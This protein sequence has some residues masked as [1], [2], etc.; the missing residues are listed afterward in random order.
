MQHLFPIT[1]TLLKFTLVYI[2]ISLFK[3]VYG[4]E[5]KHRLHILSSARRML[6]LAYPNANRGVPAKHWSSEGRKLGEQPPALLSKDK[7]R[8]LPSWSCWTTRTCCLKASSPLS[9]PPLAAKQDASSGLSV[10][11]SH[12]GWKDIGKLKPS[13]AELKTQSGQRIFPYSIMMDII[14]LS[15]WNEQ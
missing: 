4:M 8:Y 11:P 9:G 1:R 10:C 7:N 5:S 14:N 2:F 6:T 13:P 12:D 3:I 15:F